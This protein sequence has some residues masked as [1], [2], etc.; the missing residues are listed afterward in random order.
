MILQVHDE[1]NFD[2]LKKELEQAQ[3][4]IKDEMENAVSLRVPLLVDVGTGK[5]WFEAH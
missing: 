1:L 5:N 2:V 4:I 3:D